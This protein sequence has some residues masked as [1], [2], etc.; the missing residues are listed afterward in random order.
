M[1]APMDHRLHWQVASPLA[2]HW[3]KASCAEVRCIDFEHGWRIRVDALSEK[4][5]HAMR[6]S[7]RHWTVLD[8]GPG[9]TWWVFEAGQPCF[10]ASTHRAPVGRPELYVVRDRGEVKRYDRSD[11]WADDCATHTTKI[12]DK[13]MEG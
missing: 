12:V 6:V 1:A 4:D 11:Q 9:E 7:G 5:L 13:I 10:R 3:R 2:T 8:A